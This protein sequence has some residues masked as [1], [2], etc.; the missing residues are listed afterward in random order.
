MTREELIAAMQATAVNTPRPITVPKWGQIFVREVT[1]AEVDLQ[2]EQIEEMDPK[3][4]RALARGAARKICDE[5]GALLFDSTNEQD[6]ALLASQ[7]WRLLRLALADPD[8]KAEA[9]G[10]G[11]S[12]GSS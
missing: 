2:T 5:S 8:D 9:G 11:K 7:P 3:D 4:K 10:K 1:V 12:A 6:I